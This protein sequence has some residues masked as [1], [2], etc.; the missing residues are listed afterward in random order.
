MSPSPTLWQPMTASLPVLSTIRN[1]SA[2]FR[3]DSPDALGVQ[4]RGKLPEGELLLVAASK[5]HS[6]YWYCP[7]D[8]APE[9]FTVSMESF[10]GALSSCGD[11]DWTLSLGRRTKN[12]V[13]LYPLK[14]SGDKDYLRK[15]DAF[16]CDDRRRYALTVGAFAHR[17]VRYAVLPH[18]VGK[19]YSLS[20]AVCPAEDRYNQQLA[21][22]LSAFTREDD[23]LCLAVSCPDTMEQPEGFSFHDTGSDRPAT[24]FFPGQAQGTF[25]ETHTIEGRI[26]F[27][28]LAGLSGQ[29]ELTCVFRR[30]GDLLLRCPVRLAEPELA[31]ELQSRWESRPFFTGAARNCYLSVNPD[32]RLVLDFAAE[33]PGVQYPSCASLE[34][35][36]SGPLRR[37][38]YYVTALSQPSGDWQWNLLLPSLDLT[39]ADEALLCLEKVKSSLRCLCPVTFRPAHGG[40]T[41]AAAD[42]SGLPALLESCLSVNW[43]VTLAIRQGDRFWYLPVLDPLHT[44]YTSRT[45][46]TPF[47]FASDLERSPVGETLFAGQPVEGCPHWTLRYNGRLCLMVGGKCLRYMYSFACRAQQGRILFGRLT[48][49][50]QCPKINGVWVGVALTHRYKLE[51]DRQDYFFP[52]AAPKDRGNYYEMSV[53]I[54]VRRLTFTPLYWDIRAVFERDGVQFWSPIHASIRSGETADLMKE[55]GLRRL[56][57]GDSV[58]LNREQQLF[59]YRTVNNRFALV[60][61]ER[62]PYSGF[63]F[64]LKERIA[65]LLYLVFRKRLRK[66]SILLTYEKYCCMAQDNGFYFFR[67]CMEHNMEAQLKRSIYFVIDKK[68]TDYR[69]N[70]LPYKN[71]VIQFMSL[72]HMVYLLAARLLVSSDSKAHAYAWRCK[73]SIIQPYIEKNKKLVFLQHGVIALKKV[74]FFSSGTNAVSLFVTSN[75]MEHD[76]IINELGYQP[77]EVIITGLARWDVLED[78]SA[79]MNRRTILIMPTWRNWLEEVSDQVFRASD[80]YQNYMALLNS[81]RLEEYLTRYDLYL[82]FYIHPKFREY[83]G[84]FSISGERVRLIPFGSEPL[85]RLMMEC[86]LLITDYSSVCWDVFYQAKPVIFYQFDV[87]KYNE[88]QGAYIDLEHDLFGDRAVDNDQLFAL[89]EEYAAGGFQLKPQYAEMRKSLYKYIDKNNSQ[90]VCDEIQKRNW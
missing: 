1:L 24:L 16:F 51:E 40:G 86:S 53:N 6:R 42:L 13:V 84:S 79:Q 56:F 5:P 52:C 49:K 50:I 55:S 89:M 74:E 58:V 35:Y 61:Q 32:H 14:Q 44:T 25:S 17:G 26:P 45:F 28:A 11:V 81:S 65:F 29:V 9:G 47:R 27:S 73:E 18:Y 19:Q 71:H 64:R 67:H 77:Q 70:L 82:N 43:L 37:E 34:E 80:Y 85:N 12:G 88:T 20:L 87:D 2:A 39:G 30:E 57:V 23:A 54:D 46:P 62:T 68:A 21:C 72:R 36:L 4:V 7:I 69:E 8:P 66:K 63:W 3:T 33:D 22:R 41:L 78:R 90:R 83:L 76:I 10:G 59:L 38:Q 60:C 31:T 48:L 15:L 75:D